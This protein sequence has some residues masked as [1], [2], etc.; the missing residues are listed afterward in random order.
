MGFTPGDGTLNWVWQGWANTDSS[1]DAW[2]NVDSS[3]ATADTRWGVE[4]N[5]PYDQRQTQTVNEI[6][7]YQQAND[8]AHG[9]TWSQL[10]SQTLSSMAPNL[11]V[12]VKTPADVANRYGWTSLEEVNPTDNSTVSWKNGTN[13]DFT[14][15]GSLF[16]SSNK[17]YRITAYPNGGTGTATSCYLDTSNA[18]PTSISKVTGKCDA[19]SLAGSILTMTLD[20]GNVTGTV[21][22]SANI[23]VAGAVVVAM[24]GVDETTAVTTTTMDNGR[25]GLNLDLSK[26][27]SVL[28]IPTGT[29][30]KNSSRITVT[31]ADMGTI[32]LDNR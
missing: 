2:F 3:T 32:K 29:V 4:I 30:L 10:N 24:V 26:T 18:S 25:F 1:G 12:N 17:R 19:G 15:S 21:L 9:L 7:T 23:P 28:V 6:G 8:W 14:G 13:L 16:L 22:D 31:T 27:W 11:V 20:A 5:P